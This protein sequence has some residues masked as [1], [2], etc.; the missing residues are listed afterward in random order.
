M[1]FVLGPHLAVLK[2]YYWLCTQGSLL[3]GLGDHQKGC[4]GLKSG[5]WCTKANALSAE[6]S[7]PLIAFC[8]KRQP[9]SRV[10]YCWVGFFFFFSNKI[11]KIKVLQVRDWNEL[12]HCSSICSHDRTCRTDLQQLKAGSHRS[13]PL[14]VQQGQ[15]E[16]RKGILG[17]CESP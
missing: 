16:R 11:I 17:V 13:Q 2:V 14:V 12:R 4:W 8:K 6:L 15:R 10:S 7:D 3:A 9:S 1:L 5:Q